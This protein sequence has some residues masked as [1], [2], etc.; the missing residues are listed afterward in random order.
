MC[1]FAAFLQQGKEEA[2]KSEMKENTCAEVEK[3]FFLSKK[4][5]FI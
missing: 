1:L 5:K 3:T 4:I 2:R